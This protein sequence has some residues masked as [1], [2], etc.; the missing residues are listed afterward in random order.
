MTVILARTRNS[1]PFDYS[2]DQNVPPLVD[3]KFVVEHSV[4][5]NEELG[6]N[7]YSNS[8]LV[9]RELLFPVI[10]F[11]Y[12]S[13]SNLQAARQLLYSILFEYVRNKEMT[14]WKLGKLIFSRIEEELYL[15]ERWHLLLPRLLYEEFS[16][17][18]EFFSIVWAIYLYEC[19][20]SLYKTPLSERI[21]ALPRFP[22]LIY[23]NNDSRRYEPPAKIDQGITINLLVEFYMNESFFEW[24][25][26]VVEGDFLQNLQNRLETEQL[27][28]RHIPVEDFA[29]ILAEVS[30]GLSFLEQ[31][32]IDL[33]LVSIVRAGFCPFVELLVVFEF[34]KRF[35]L[36]ANQEN[37]F[38]N[39]R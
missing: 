33:L 9:I 12:T 27:W 36:Y 3:K 39:N 17:S 26:H 6:E 14:P 34:E 32:E 11:D 16:A 30:Y 10:S 25:S 31:K 5:L 4:E 8:L 2:Y 21:Q 28:D 15:K 18:E 1:I 22:F 13:P 24:L 38:I 19:K 29:R 7:F 35:L 37:D 23:Y 20:N